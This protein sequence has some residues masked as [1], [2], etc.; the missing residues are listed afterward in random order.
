MFEFDDLEEALPPAKAY[1]TSPMRADEFIRIGEDLRSSIKRRS[2]QDLGVAIG[3]ALWEE[4]TLQLRLRK[5]VKEYYSALDEICSE[6]LPD[7]EAGAALTFTLFNLSLSL[8]MHETRTV[9]QAGPV[10]LIL[11]FGGSCCDDLEPQVDW[12]KQQGF[13][14][15]STC[16]LSFPQ[17]LA[18]KQ[19]ELVAE[20]LRA[21]LPA[22]GR[23]VLHLCSHGGCCRAF[24]M[25][26]KW[27]SG[28]A[29]YDSLPPLEETLAAIIFECAPA[30]TMDAKGEIMKP[31]P[32]VLPEGL[33]AEKKPAADAEA[34]K[35][36]EVKGEEKGEEKKGKAETEEKE[37]EKAAEVPMEQIMEGEV[38]FY[39]MVM[40]GCIGALFTKFV[41]DKGNLGKLMAKH[42][43][44]L[45]RCLRGGAR[46]TVLGLP[47]W[48]L[49]EQVPTR[50]YGFHDF[51]G[52]D[53]RLKTP[54]PR[55]FL[56]SERDAL[57]HK[58]KV[59]AYCRY[60]RWYNPR[61]TILTAALKRA[62]HCKLWDSEEK[63]VCREAVLKLLSH[64]DLSSVGNDKVMGA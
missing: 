46:Y 61:A 38:E 31:P 36:E 44:P 7:V 63:E 8:S 64:A 15:I 27:V 4:D 6:D 51:E 59:E 25:L 10:V 29:P 1:A 11:G 13:S 54:I 41:P 22:R 60:S 19:N 16:P 35:G 24:D 28:E 53:A 26:G 42:K 45:T 52:W 40:M 21:T 49:V 62:A 32:G 33:E 2:F 5:I 58:S 56:H 23:L 9:R 3:R 57:V 14:V 17:E 47:E 30:Q 55:L 18:A 43:D 50:V 20:A 34:V 37:Q 12:Y 48:A 39:R